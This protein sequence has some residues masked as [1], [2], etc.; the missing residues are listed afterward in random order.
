M[1]E[2]FELVDGVRDTERKPSLNA[3]RFVGLLC[4]VLASSTAPEA[5]QRFIDACVASAADDDVQ[6]ADMPSVCA[7][8]AER[9]ISQGISGT[10]LDGLMQYVGADGNINLDAAPEPVRALSEVVIEGLF[11]CLFDSVQGQVDAT[12]TAT[13]STPSPQARSPRRV[14]P[15]RSTSR[16]QRRGAGSAIRIQG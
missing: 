16:V 12:P 9:A 2:P 1:S 13:S 4:L 7:C 6:G 3:M 8:G 14:A 11:S 15:T 10:S 5:Q